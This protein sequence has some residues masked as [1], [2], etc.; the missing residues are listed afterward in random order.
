LL[1]IYNKFRITVTT[2]SVLMGL[3]FP[4]LLYFLGGNCLQTSFSSYY[5][6]DAKWYL[7]SFLVIMSLGFFMGDHKYKVSGIL[8]L[9][10][11]TVDITYP[12]LHNIIAVLFFGYTATLILMDKRF[13][14]L[15][16]P[17]FIAAFSIPAQGLYIFEFISVWCIASFNGL[18]ILRFLRVIKIR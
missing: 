8:L 4:L 1:T 9:A 14:M 15:A 5:E 13:Y 18:Y 2:I 10:I 11:A 3:L 6:T 7:F 17:M 16:I 12:M